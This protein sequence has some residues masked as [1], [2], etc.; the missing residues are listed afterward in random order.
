MLALVMDYGRDLNSFGAHWIPHIWKGNLVQVLKHV[1]AICVFYGK[2][3]FATLLEKSHLFHLLFYC[4]LVQLQL[5]VRNVIATHSFKV[6]LR[7]GDS[8]VTLILS[9]KVT[10]AQDLV[11][12]SLLG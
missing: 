10:H 9:V 4:F 8:R 1:L 12:F 11:N 2:D 7:V 6:C 5:V 3:L